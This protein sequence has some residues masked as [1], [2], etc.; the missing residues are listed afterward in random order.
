MMKQPGSPQ[1]IDARNCNAFTASP[2]AGIW[3][4]PGAGGCRT[5]RVS[6]QCAEVFVPTII[7]SALHVGVAQRFYLESYGLNPE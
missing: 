5:I 6:T 3:L 1:L 7:G 2:Y 4:K